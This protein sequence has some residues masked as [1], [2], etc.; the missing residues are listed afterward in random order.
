MPAAGPF[1]DMVC[2]QASVDQDP[3]EAE[4][5]IRKNQAGWAMSK[6]HCVTF[7]DTGAILWSVH[8][9]RTG[10]SADARRLPVTQASERT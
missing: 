1:T 6:K 5:E 10:K 2:R 7:A 8:P 4:R 3:L 9:E